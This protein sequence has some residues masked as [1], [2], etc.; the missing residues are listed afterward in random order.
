MQAG[1]L[2]HLVVLQ[3]LTETQDPSTGA[4]TKSWVDFAT[5]WG[6]VRY[7]SGLE[8]VKADAPTSVAKCSVRIRYLAGVVPTMRLVHAGTNFDINAVLP[9]DTGRRWLDLACTAGANQG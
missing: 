4:I 6:D 7:L 2:R 9:D 3:S 5:V 8:T 1:K